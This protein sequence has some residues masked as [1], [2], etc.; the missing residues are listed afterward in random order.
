[1]R[2]ILSLPLHYEQDVVTSRQRAGQIAALLGYEEADQTR[3]ATAVSE[4]ARNAFRYARGGEVAFAVD[5]DA[6]P[7]RFVVRVVDAGPGIPRLDDILAGRYRSGTGLGKGIVGARRLVDHFDIRSSAA[8]TEVELGRALPPQAAPLTRERLG[9]LIAQIQAWRPH[10]LVEE[11]QAQNR[12][13]LS[14][15]DELQ[16]RQQDLLRLNRELED[17]NRSVVALY[18]ELDDKADDLRRADE[19]KTRFLSNMT[20]EFRTPVNAIIGLCALVTDDR[21]RAGRE[22]EPE[23][24]HIRQAAGQLAVLVDDLLDLAKVEAGKTVVRPDTFHVAQLFGALRGMFRPLLVSQSVALAFDPAEDLP[25]L[26][27]DEARVSQ[28]LRN[29]ISNA[30]KFTERGEVRVSAAA[31]GSDRVAFSVADTGIGIAPE[32]QR[33]IFEE[34]AQLEHR[35]QRGARGTGLG[36]TLSRRLAELLGGRL[37]VDSRPGLGSTFRLTLPRRYQAGAAPPEAPV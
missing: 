32:D 22:P 31:E 17:T 20:H 29:L 6:R 9:A 3:I 24:H 27:T 37:S 1:M 15:L 12:A 33:R 26:W 35:L 11:I 19:L 10:G 23:L 8:G 4:I 2:H 21:R 13:L 25:P 28:I 5:A 18:T 16:R 30:L 36:L 14:A 34:F 7:Q